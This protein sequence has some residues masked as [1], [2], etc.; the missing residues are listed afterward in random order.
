[1]AHIAGK[2]RD[3]GHLVCKTRIPNYVNTEG[4]ENNE[5]PLYHENLSLSKP[6]RINPNC[7]PYMTCCMGYNKINFIYSVVHNSAYYE[8][9]NLYK[10]NGILYDIIVSISSYNTYYNNTIFY[11]VLCVRKGF[12]NLKKI[13][14]DDI[15]QHILK[16]LT[17]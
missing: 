16:F 13:I 2:S 6:F 12:L 9:Y 1:M 17:G 10:Y 7:S 5:I 4:K 3:F 11:I 14:P 15:T 8:L